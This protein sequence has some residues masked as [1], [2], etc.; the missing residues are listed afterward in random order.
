MFLFFHFDL[1]LYF[2]ERY[3]QFFSHILPKTSL[4]RQLAL[5]SCAFLNLV[6]IVLLN[7]VLYKYDFK[8]V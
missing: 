7:S 4:K 3:L 8:E 2:I 1:S 5:S 6:A